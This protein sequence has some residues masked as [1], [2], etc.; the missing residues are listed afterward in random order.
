MLSIMALVFE[1][2]DAIEYDLK[3][4]YTDNADEADILVFENYGDPVSKPEI[5][6]YVEDAEDAEWV[7]YF[8]DDAEEADAIVHFVEEPS[9]ARIVNR[10]KAHL[11]RL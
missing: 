9:E 4:C 8:V 5:W 3:A 7:V 1:T 2:D 10:S 11:F 6:T